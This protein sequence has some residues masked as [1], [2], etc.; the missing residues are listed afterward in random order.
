[1]R[2]SAHRRPGGRHR[3]SQG[4]TE[5]AAPT[6]LTLVTRSLD[7]QGTGQQRGTMRGKP[8]STAGSRIRLT[9]GRHMRRHHQVGTQCRPRGW[10]VSVTAGILLLLSAC[11]SGPPPGEAASSARPTRSTSGPVPPV[12]DTTKSAFAHHDGP[13]DV[14]TT[15]DDDDPTF[16]GKPTP[17]Q[18]FGDIMSTRLRHGPQ[19][20]QVRVTFVDLSSSAHLNAPSNLRL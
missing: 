20:V 1:M 3:P 17:H 5:Q 18:V 19:D 12:P 16:G 10:V 7:S 2:I 11:S 13:G 8:R 9:R 14:F 4:A 6:C 15:A